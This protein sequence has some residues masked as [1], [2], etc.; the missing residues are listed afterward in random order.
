M[1]LTNSKREIAELFVID[2]KLAKETRVNRLVNVECNPRILT[3][4]DRII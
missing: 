4:L 1:H 2:S 3:T